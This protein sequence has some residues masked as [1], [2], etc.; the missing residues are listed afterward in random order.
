MCA[1]P[2]QSRP[3]LCDSMD[4]SPPGSSVHGIFQARILQ[5]VSMS[6][7][8]G[9]SPPMGRNC[10]SCITV[11]FFT[12][13]ATWEACIYIY[14]CILYIR[15]YIDFMHMFIYVCMCVYMHIYT[16]Y[17]CILTFSTLQCSLKFTNIDVQTFNYPF[18]KLYNTPLHDTQ[19]IYTGFIIPD[20]ING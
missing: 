5:W 8:R 2:L 11:R 1:Q 9:S 19:F 6:F 15:M 7:S 20:S 14:M 16:H 13:W 4:C 17:F 10:I 12:H 3:T 18:M